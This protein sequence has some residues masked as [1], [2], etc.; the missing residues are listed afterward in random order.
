MVTQIPTQETID[1]LKTRKLSFEAFLDHVDEDSHAE[2]VDGEILMASPASLK[3]QDLSG[4]LTTILRLFVR[5][6]KLGQVLDSPFLVRLQVSDQAREPDLLFLKTE[7]LGRLKET[8]VEGPPDL[9]I[10]IISPESI[11]RDRGRKFVEYEQEGIPE[12]WLLDPLRQQAEF[13]RRGEDELFHV[14]LPNAEGL[15]HSEAVAGFWLQTDWLWQ[16][17]LPD[18]FSILRQLGVLD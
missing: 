17:P 9:V 2:W 4:W 6:K 5:T 18:E 16:S 8:Y 10:E 15:Y 3:H 13:Y 7:N 1:T 12:Y 11:D 14:V